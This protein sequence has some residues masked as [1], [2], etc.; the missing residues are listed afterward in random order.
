MCSEIRLQLFTETRHSQHA[1]L[2]S[3]FPPNEVM[4][5][6]APELHG[7]PQLKGEELPPA[8]VR[9]SQAQSICKLKAGKQ[10]SGTLIT[11]V[12]LNWTA[13]F[14]AEPS[15]ANN[16][17]GLHQSLARQA[18]T[19]PGYRWRKWCSENPRCKLQSRTA[20][21]GT[22]LSTGCHEVKLCTYL[23][24]DFRQ[25]ATL[26]P[27]ELGALAQKKDRVS[28][29]KPTSQTNSPCDGCAWQNSFIFL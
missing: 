28:H 18:L 27:T 23:F 4:P 6:A 1:P 13:S 26:Y 11:P 5:A 24:N 19:H 2:R 21:F 17:P 14:R 12:A 22:S 9:G 25:E 15:Q 8:S 3:A 7:P 29:I 10:E 16:T 20:N